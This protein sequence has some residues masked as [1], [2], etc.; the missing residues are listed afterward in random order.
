MNVALQFEHVCGDKDAAA[1]DIVFIHGITG[2]PK[3]T[4]TKHQ[5]IEAFLETRHA[6]RT[7]VLETTDPLESAV[8]PSPF[9]SDLTGTK[10]LAV[11]GAHNLRHN[12][13]IQE[14]AGATR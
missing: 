4:W 8:A 10:F 7:Y 5:A 12:Q 6:T 11:I 3:E 13:Q 1:L 2:D 14:V 9:G